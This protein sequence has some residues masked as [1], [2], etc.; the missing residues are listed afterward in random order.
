M[1]KKIKALT[2]SWNGHTCYLGKINYNELKNVVD[3][4]S[5][6]SMNRDI[7]ETRV[8]K[9]IDYLEK[10]EVYNAFFPPA[11]LSSSVKLVYNPITTE[12]DVKEGRFTVIDG[13][14]RIDAIIRLN[15]KAEGEVAKRLNRM[16]LPVLII[17]GLES[18]Q[19]RNLFFLINESAKRVDSNIS[20]RFSEKIENL[21]GL[22]FLSDNIDFCKDIEWEKK[23]S[24]DETKVAY[25]H[26]T[27]C[28]RELHS[29]LY[30]HLKDHLGDAE[31]VYKNTHYFEIMSHFLTKTL[32]FI[33]NLG[34][35]ERKFF[36]KKI[37]L[38][39]IV[40]D[41][42]EE[43]A[44]LFK[45]KRASS[46]DITV[47][48]QMVKDR[49]DQS[50]LFTLNTPLIDYN[51][52]TGT[53]LSTYKTRRHFLNLNGYLH[54][55]NQNIIEVRPL[56]Q[57]IIDLYYVETRKLELSHEDYQQYYNTINNVVNNLEEF[58]QLTLDHIDDIVINKQ[59]PVNEIIE[60]LKQEEQQ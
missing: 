7:D 43:I 57:K 42:C 17:E 14:H 19:H 10:E 54:L 41:V 46:L 40:L 39:A 21:I 28:I 2:Y 31:L 16:E 15:K 29:E 9:I 59:M 4:E 35:N 45:T 49:M 6:L 20:E 34:D 36:T 23:Q 11:V 27:D 12:L 30:D 8:E 18:S 53:K 1:S 13:Q 33:F 38:R 5:D 48:V 50:F 37:S 32:K 47:W 60:S 25:I 51:G 24:F 58:K 3:I 52:E 56:L 26:L 44:Y 55:Q 22:R